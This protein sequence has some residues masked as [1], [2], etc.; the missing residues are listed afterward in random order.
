MRLRQTYRKVL[1]LAVAMAALGALAAAQ[2]VTSF[3]AAPALSRY[4]ETSMRA[5]KVPGAAVGIVRGTAPVYL[6]GFGVRDVRTGQAVTPDTLFDIGSCT[7]AF[8]AAAAAMLVDEGKMRWDGKVRDYIP[9][10]QLYDPLADEQVTLRDLLT[11][12]TGVPGTD[13]LWYGTH[14]TRAQVIRR[15]RYAKPDAGFRAAF[16][17]QNV[18][19]VAAGYAV[20][21][22]AGET[23][24]AF[25]QQR[26]FAPLGMSESDTSAEAVQRSP[27]HA[28]PHV[29]APD[30][31]VHAIAYRNIDN[32][33]PAGSINSS[34]RD[35]A[36]W[37]GL[38]LND[39]VYDGRRLISDASMQAMHTPQMV[40]PMQ[41]EIGRVF[42]PDSMQLSY[43]LGWFIQDYR[44]HQLILHPGD[45]DGFSALVVLIPEIHTGYVVLINLGG[46]TYR[47]V[48][49]YHI[50][51]L[52]LH[53]PPEHW[54]AYFRRLQTRLA[55]EQ[56]QQVADFMKQRHPAT[57]TTLPL[58]DYDGNYANPL[59]GPATIT[60][61]DGH[62]VFHVFDRTLPLTH[63]QYDTFLTSAPN[64]LTF[65][66]D[67]RGRVSEFTYSGARFQRKH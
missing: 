1:C 30:G 32:A 16:Q 37:I 14:L 15:L 26:I 39:G 33:G 27:N 48:L 13:M 11:H 47:Q 23:W 6:R 40:V 10:F 17:Y 18:M 35:M 38:Q 53:L 62:L 31:R 63:F 29:E 8:T 4:I 34:V 52:L 65:T 19:Y 61:A 20:G 55:S 66:L 67:A 64:A 24:D 3:T 28:A 59:W 22:A 12:R 50:A 60:L 49:G 42:F 43:G 51:D 56:K 21:Q 57:H 7:K 46:G 25:V 54:G 58:A 36:R 5:W 41:S 2:A 9:W 45:I 44:G